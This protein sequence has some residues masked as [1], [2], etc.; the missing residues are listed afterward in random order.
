MIIEMI[1]DVV[2]N[3]LNVSTMKSCYLPDDNVDIEEVHGP[4]AV[5]NLQLDEML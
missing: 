5:S 4:Y 2:V 3:S 1:V